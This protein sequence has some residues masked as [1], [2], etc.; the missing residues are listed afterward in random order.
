M[1]ERPSILRSKSR[2]NPG[3]SGTRLDPKAWKA[4]H[5]QCPRSQFGRV[6]SEDFVSLSSMAHRM[7]PSATPPLSCGKSN[8]ALLADDGTIDTLSS[9]GA[10][11]VKS[12][13][14]SATRA[15][16]L[17]RRASPK[18]PRSRLSPGTSNA[19]FSNHHHHSLGGMVNQ[20]PLNGQ[21]KEI[22]PLKPEQDHRH[23]QETSRPSVNRVY[24]SPAPLTSVPPNK[25]ESGYTNMQFSQDFSVQEASR[26]L[27]MSDPS[28]DLKSMTPSSPG[29]DNYG[30]QAMFRQPDTNP[31]TEEQLISEVRGIYSGLV[32][33]EQKC[34]DVDKQQAESES[35]TELSGSQWQALI[36]LHR[37]L[38]Y[39]HHDFFL[40]SQH[41]SA[42]KVLKNLAEKYAMPA[43]MWRFGIHS[44][45]ELL[46]QKL[47]GSL[48]YMLNFIYIAYSMMTLLLESVVAFRETWIECLGDIARYRMAIEE[49]D[50][51]DREIWVGV[52]RYWYNQGA[53]ESPN[54]GR[55][56]HH[57]AVLARPDGLQQLF[58]YTK[59]L[60]SVEPFQTARD[61]IALLLNPYKGQE[62]SQPTM[63][64]AFLATHGI[65][66]NQ[67]PQEQFIAS[68]NHFLSLLRK[69][70]RRLGQQRHYGVY[71][72][73]CNLSTILQYGQPEVV[74]DLEFLQDKKEL[75]S[76]V[77]RVAL[78]WTSSSASSSKSEPTTSTL[79]SSAIAAQGS[80]LTFHT[81]A[82]LL[83][84]PSNEQMYPSI[85]ISLAFI[86]CIALRPIAMQQFEQVIPWLPIAKFLNTLLSSGIDFSNSQNEEFPVYDNE[87][88]SRQLPEDFLIRG[89]VWSQLYYPEGFF[90][91]AHSEDNLTT[92]ETSATII[93]RRQRCVWLG[94]R[95]AT[96][97]RWITY[98]RDEGFVPTQFAHECSA[99]AQSHGHLNSHALLAEPVNDLEMSEA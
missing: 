66:F 63:L 54:V 56:Q 24:S 89:Q 49:S 11:K 12:S 73:S 92:G 22:I 71:M 50:L 87:S 69:D 30:Y 32:M 25:T 67:G 82:I 95:I 2:P 64:T 36:S 79:S 47:P 45:L 37:T 65:L 44:L 84:E 52:S 58:Y 57:L 35:K 76:E 93:P 70:V 28:S 61:S 33:V 3:A 94:V 53:D 59:S 8:S 40:A 91:G 80:A 38:I 13:R 83:N 48:D 7:R 6:R 18:L 42:S 55:I 15:E 4:A 98:S 72:M 29:T 23:Y 99:I 74:M 5:S 39:E 88:G 75:V 17:R 1:G 19:H 43:R 14:P 21:N 81:L 34:I 51:G 85:H 68:A 62:L 27:E 46:R 78:G 31:I 96:F 86:W 10:R 60:V 9:N 90:Y 20:L 16:K 26:D 97:R 41:P 77:H